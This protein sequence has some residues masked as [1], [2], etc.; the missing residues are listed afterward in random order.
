[1]TNATRTATLPTT[2]FIAMPSQRFAA[3]FSFFFF[4]FSFV[5]SFGL[6]CFL[7]R[8]MPLAMTAKYVVGD[9]SQR[10]SAHPLLPVRREAAH[11]HGDVA[12]AAEDGV[13]QHAVR[14]LRARRDPHEASAGA[15]D[16][17]HVLESGREQLVELAALHATPH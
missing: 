11:V 6:F 12:L 5:E 7:P 2:H 1:M 16:A 9:T 3:C 4:C 13:L 15:K 14:R 17:R 10:Q 8:S